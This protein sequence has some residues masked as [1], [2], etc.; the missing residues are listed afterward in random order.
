MKIAMN[1]KAAA[2][3]FT[4]T[5]FSGSVETLVQERLPAAV[6]AAVAQRLQAASTTSADEIGWRLL[7]GNNARELPMMNYD[8]QQQVAYWLY[9]TNPMAGWMIDCMVA[10]VTTDGLPFSCESD[11]VKE[12]LTT[13]WERN[14]LPLRFSKYVGE[15]GI[16]GNIVLTAHVAEQ[17]GRV[18]L[19][20]IDPGLIQ[21]TIT[22]PE[23]VQTK[24]GMVLKATDTRAGRTLR[25]ILDADTEEDLSPAAKNMREQ[26]TE[27][28][29]YFSVNDL[30]SELLGTSDLFAVA[31]HLE[32]Y[33]QFIFDSA[34][35]WAE[36][37]SFWTDVEV[38]GATNEELEKNKKNYLPPK[39][40]G[41]FVHNEKVKMTSVSPDLKAPDAEKAARLARNHILSAR[42]YPEHWY[43]GGGDI[44]RATAAEMDAPTLKALEKRRAIVQAMLS[45]VFDFAIAEA[46][47]A[48][49]LTVNDEEEAY[50]YELQSPNL[51]DKDVAK[52]ASM[53]T[54]VA[55]SL[56]VAQN[57]GW[58]TTE[59]AARMYAFCASMI[60][61]TYDADE[62]SEKKGYDDYQD[63]KTKES[64]LTDPTDK[65][66]V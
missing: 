59:Q 6:E 63:K 7:T 2:T 65:G 62:E 32:V 60:G 46:L 45:T 17:T 27:R 54:Q 29:F 5:F 37:N 52:L 36:F 64:D 19:G 41:S 39:S 48:R 18:K 13:F 20:Y 50:N 3:A 10:F 58:I 35:K 61:F 31:D 44:N 33:E 25:I 26:W 30:S 8:R 12:I 49:Y 23:D 15:L 56:T 34:E 21:T 55:T 24:I 14:R 1:L 4:R 28:C 42:S 51:V 9:K 38:N 16:F 22:D 43:G 40:G 47:N 66:R 11:D 57:N 53:L